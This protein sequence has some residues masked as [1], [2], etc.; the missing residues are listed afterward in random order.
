[1]DANGQRFWMW[2]QPGD[3]HL[4]AG[5]EVD[6]TD[7]RL[8]LASRRGP[9]ATLPP[10]VAASQ[11]LS[12]LERVPMLRDD[13]ATYAWWDSAA[14]AVRA[15][16]AAGA[17]VDLLPLPTGPAPS[18]IAL[19]EDGVLYIA[20]E[21]GVTLVDARGRFTPLQVA[22]ADFQ[23]WRLAA[24]P[25]GGA[26]VLDRGR[27]RLAR[28]A[29]RVL[30]D[31]PFAAYAPSTFRPQPDNPDPPRLVVLGDLPAGD[32]PV[33]L[34][35]S[36]QG[37]VAVLTWRGDGEGWLHRF[38]ATTGFAAARRLEDCRYPFSIAWIERGAE[39]KQIALLV[40]G[41]AEALVYAAQADAGSLP[42]LGEVLPLLDHDGGPFL[43]ASPG[44]PHYPVAGAAAA[45]GTPLRSRALHRLSLH[46]YAAAGEAGGARLAP[47]DVVG[48]E[49]NP[50][51]PADGGAPA[52][53]WHRICLEALMPP[54]CAAVVWLAATEDPECPPLSGEGAAD[55]WHPHLF[56]DAERAAVLGLDPQTPRA[57]WTPAASELPH[58]E[59][60]L[61]CPREPLRAGLFSALV[62][63]AGRRVRRLIGRYLW[64]RV[65]LLG[66]GR[67]TPEIAALRLWGSRFSY[68][69]RY[70][71][72]LYREQEFARADERGARSTPA[73]FLERFLGNFEGVLTPLEDR[74]AAA[75]VLTD[76]DSV[77]EAG[78]EWLADWIGFSFAQEM[79]ASRRRAM[80]R[81]A[82]RLYALRGTQA[83][84]ELALDA[85][86]GG[87]VSRGAL[88][89][90]EDFRLRRTFATLLGVDFERRAD[91]LL[92]GLI[93]SGNS[94]VGDTL[95]LGDETR[96]EFLALFGPGIDLSAQE[97]RVVA[98]FFERFAHRVTVL[99]HEA[100]DVATLALVRAIVARETPAHVQARVVVTTEPLLVGIRSLV[101]VD[102]YLREAAPARP[103]RLSA[104]RVGVRDLLLGRPLLDTAQATAASEPPQARIGA[105]ATP[106][107]GESF[108]L[109]GSGSTAA[110]GRTIR[111]YIWQRLA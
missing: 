103:V 79:P 108:N 70:L 3:W 76:P 97:Q 73:D 9:T 105:P 85:A 91:P 89:V 69:Q 77:P 52:I 101:A 92:P 55:A 86:T 57:A 59:G 94:F 49:A 82:P 104:S 18:D 63:R 87:W 83:G 81:I 56:G 31:R 1:M 39:P 46:A 41:L 16:G 61:G 98:E 21:Q 25:D 110:A 90:V 13:A 34:A 72:E 23:P 6:A 80:L 26:W 7:R 58:H 68:A 65:T 60:V 32:V 111:R 67:H 22:A 15:A 40:P 36:G 11:G 62:Q 93:V 66:D 38:D 33:A 64:V 12:A 51:R 28:L 96:R 27:R 17:A 71:A 106:A 14:R 24:D 53:E 75:H 74:I 8:R 43:H 102:T 54:H 10:D 109:D 42:A 19:G 20:L 35:V 88:V 37:E 29:G 47:V 4:D 84:L 50:L 30:P 78:V 107:W 48:G 99:A 44:L 95:V 45:D 2:S 5:C 100:L